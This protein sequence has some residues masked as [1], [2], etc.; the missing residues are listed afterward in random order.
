MLLAH[1]TVDAERRALFNAGKRMPM[2]TAMI[3]M[4]TSNSTSVNPAR[5][6]RRWLQSTESHETET[7]VNGM[8]WAPSI[9]IDL[10]RNVFSLY[11]KNDTAP[12]AIPAFDAGLCRCELLPNQRDTAYLR[13]EERP[14][15]ICGQLFPTLVSARVD[16]ARLVGRR[17]NQVARD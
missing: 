14:E 6:T 13:Q 9:T 3:P 8:N 15:H 10:K 5:R 7:W 2:R 4:T 17:G 1:C 11:L 16:H 12:R